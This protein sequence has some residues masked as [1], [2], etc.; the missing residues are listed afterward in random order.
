MTTCILHEIIGE[1]GYDFCFPVPRENFLKIADLLDGKPRA[2]TWIPPNME[3]I[4]VDDRGR[5]LEQ[6]DA[7]WFGHDAL[8]LKPKAVLAVGNYL[9]QHGELL[10]LKCAD[11]NVVIY[12]VTRVI[13]ALDEN[14]SKIERFE[15]GRIMSIDQP[16]FRASKIR[17]IDVFKLPL[18][19]STLYVAQPFVDRWNKH[20]LRGIT[21]KPVWST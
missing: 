13:D 17:G 12:N 14:A 21:F 1:D 3:M 11:A 20:G 8:V 18:R 4:R 2:A 19:R 16:A 6:A 5:T 7:P 9:Q 15:D 10:P